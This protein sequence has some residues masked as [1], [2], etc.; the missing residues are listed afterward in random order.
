MD[1][2][3]K[4]CFVRTEMSDNVIFSCCLVQHFTFWDCA[5]CQKINPK[6][7]SL[8]VLCSVTLP[9]NGNS[10]I[11]LSPSCHS[12]PVCCNYLLKLKSLCSFK[13]IIKLV[14]MTLYGYIKSSEARQ[15]VK[16]KPKVAHRVKLLH[17]GEPMPF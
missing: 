15:Y 11:I 7:L 10:F 13:N 16:N 9:R 4:R 2:A 12:K 8:K 14:D 17:P 5:L 3:A 6:C 1:Y